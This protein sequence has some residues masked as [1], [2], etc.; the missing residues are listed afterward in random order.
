VAG[1]RKWSFQVDGNKFRLVL[2]SERILLAYL[3]GPYVA[4]SSSTIERCS[5]RSVR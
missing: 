3:F 2:E 5:G 1:S 4:V